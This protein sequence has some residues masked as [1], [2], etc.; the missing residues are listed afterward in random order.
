MVLTAEGIKDLRLDL[1]LESHD[2]LGTLDL[3]KFPLSILLHLP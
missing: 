2:E 1:L 3:T